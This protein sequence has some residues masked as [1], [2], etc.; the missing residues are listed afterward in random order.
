LR[1]RTL[2]AIPDVQTVVI[3]RNEGRPAGASQEHPHSQ[4]VALPFVPGRL[5]D[6]MTVAARHFDAA[7]TCLTC[8][9]VADEL[10]NGARVVARNE[11]FVALA[12]FAPRFGFET[13]IVPVSH[14]HDFLAADPAAIRGL[15]GMLSKVLASLETVHGAFPYNLVL[16]TAP[17]HTTPEIDRSFHWR[18]EIMP[19]LTTPSGLELGADVFIVAVT[20]E[21]AAESLR[22]ALR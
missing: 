1:A 14:Q 4:I 19:R 22:A 16:Q 15:A 12:S 5:R 20:P 17:V 6:E 9:L 11:D 3:L 8:D 13:W 7:G 18:L 10:A 2:G 21:Q